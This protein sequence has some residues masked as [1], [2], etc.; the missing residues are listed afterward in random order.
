MDVDLEAVNTHTGIEWAD[1]D[2]EDVNI[3]KGGPSWASVIAADSNVFHSSTN[4]SIERRT[5]HEAG[6][7]D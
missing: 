3:S 5:S 4:G 1:N 2:S 7:E 6:G